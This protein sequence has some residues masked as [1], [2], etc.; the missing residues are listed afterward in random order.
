MRRVRFGTL[1]SRFFTKHRTGRQFCEK[2][3]ATV[4]GFRGARGALQ[5]LLWLHAQLHRPLELLE[6]ERVK[7]REHVARVRL[8]HHVLDADH[9]KPLL[10]ITQNLRLDLLREELVHALIY[11]PH[12]NDKLRST[13]LQ[14]ALREIDL[15]HVLM[16]MLTTTTADTFK[17]ILYI[18]V[19]RRDGMHERRKGLLW[20]CS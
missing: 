13:R 1:P 15:R 6:I 17:Q 12:G 2:Q 20:N 7:A 5:E 14:E 16:F 10:L 3:K 8:A 9:E 4:G 11:W 19:G 18:A